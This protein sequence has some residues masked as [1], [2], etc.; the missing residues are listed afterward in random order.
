MSALNL[1]LDELVAVVRTCELVHLSRCNLP[2][3][4]HLIARRL[5]A[6][7][8]PLAQKVRG[9]DRRQMAQ[10]CGYIRLTHRLVTRQLQPA[11]RGAAVA[12]AT[13]R[14][15]DRA[16]TSS[17]GGL[18]DGGSYNG[19]DAGPVVAGV[20]AVLLGPGG[21]SPRVAPGRV[22]SRRGQLR[23]RPSPG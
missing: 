20:A 13:E 14:A 21:D 15:R 18:R 8:P 22:F 9:F 17:G 2:Y 1:S 4:G 16:V 11:N 19:G 5:D 7:A 12:G 10:L 6:T 3:L 23:R